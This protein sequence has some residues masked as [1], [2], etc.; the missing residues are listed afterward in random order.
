MAIKYVAAIWDE[1]ETVYV[2]RNGLTPILNDA[3]LF[4]EYK[5]TI[6][7]IMNWLPVFI[8]DDLIDNDE[9]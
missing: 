7:P 1:D 2:S 6:H 5:Q 9:I 4:D 3:V 8:V